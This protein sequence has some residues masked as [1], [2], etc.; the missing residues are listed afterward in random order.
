MASRADG[1]LREAPTVLHGGRLEA[2]FTR[3]APA[4][5]LCCP[6]QPATRV[7][8]QLIRQPA[9]WVLLPEAA[10]RVP[11][12]PFQLPRTGFPPPVPRLPLL[13]ATLAMG[14]LPACATRAGATLT[15]Y[16]AYP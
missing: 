8:Y 9:G 13:A 11:T 12:V 10:T 6:S 4:D 7:S 16:S 5:P 1:V 2:T 3:Y 15:E 14:A